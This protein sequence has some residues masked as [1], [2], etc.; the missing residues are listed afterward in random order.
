MEFNKLRQTQW[1][2]LNTQRGGSRFPAGSKA[3][4]ARILWI[5]GGI[6]ATGFQTQIADKVEP[7]QRRK[8]KCSRTLIWITLPARLSHA[9]LRSRF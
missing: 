9:L 2:A 1:A 8:V 3:M 4:A 5:E 6:E 7:G